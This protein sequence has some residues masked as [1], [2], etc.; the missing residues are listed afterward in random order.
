MR[1]TI[2]RAAVVNGVPPVWHDF[3]KQPCC[4]S[5]A[6]DRVVTFAEQYRFLQA[7]ELLKD[8]RDEQLATAWAMARADS[9]DAVR[10]S[11][12]RIAPVAAEWRRLRWVSAS[13]D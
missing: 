3:R 1:G 2:G 5:V 12:Q 4:T 9:F 10:D 11:S 13:W 7:G 6:S 8:A